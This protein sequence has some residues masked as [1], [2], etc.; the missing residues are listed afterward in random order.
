MGPN[1]ICLDK[2]ES[3]RALTQKENHVKT[4][5]EDGYL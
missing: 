4:Q 2:E 1:P 5:G 3:V